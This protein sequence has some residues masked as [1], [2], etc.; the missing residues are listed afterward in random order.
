MGLTSIAIGV[1]A[2][3]LIF[4]IIRLFMKTFKLVMAITVI[5]AIVGGLYGYS[6]LFDKVSDAKDIIPELGIQKIARSINGCTT[7]Q[8]CAYLISSGDCRQV[9]G[10]CNNVLEAENYKKVLDDNV[11]D[12]E[13]NRTSREID[14]TIDCDCKLH[15]EREGIIKQWLGKKLEEKAGYTYCWK[16]EP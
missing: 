10:Y 1:L 5:L 16:K 15:K 7:E 12:E 8:D 9:A 6:G 2:I 13:C 14:Y 3:A 11:L 4:L